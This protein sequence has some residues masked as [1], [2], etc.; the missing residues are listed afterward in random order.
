MAA[1]VSGN[2]TFEELSVSGGSLSGSENALV[3]SAAG[4]VSQTPTACA[5]DP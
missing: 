2:P 4:P 3:H 1:T 5:P